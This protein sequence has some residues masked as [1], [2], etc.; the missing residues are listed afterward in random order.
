DLSPL[1]IRSVEI[2]APPSGSLAGRLTDLHSVPLAGVSVL[3]RNLTTG[4]EARA[5]TAKNGAFHFDRLDAGE[6]MLQADAAQLGHGELGGILV[7]GGAVARVQ[8]AMRFEPP[9][10]S[11]IEAAAPSE[12]PAVQVAA[13]TIPLPAY[14]VPGKSGGP[15]GLTSV[16]TSRPVH[17]PSRPA[18]LPPTAIRIEKPAALPQQ[19]RASIETHSPPV[20]LS[21]EVTVPHTLPLTFSASPILP[22][23]AAIASGLHAAL[24]LGE[25][26]YSPIS[27]AA[28]SPDPGA[29]STTTIMTAAQLQSLPAG[30]RR[31]QEFL[32]DTPA[33]SPSADSSEQSYRA[34]QESAGV[35]IDGANTSLRFGV[36][37]GSAA[38]STPQERNLLN[39][40]RQSTVGQSMSQAWNGGRGAGI[41]EAAISEVTATAGNV[42]AKAMRS[43]GGRTGI[44]TERG[45]NA[46]HGQ[47]FLYDRQN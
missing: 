20:S 35:T 24:R 8:A 43:A 15:A 19:L 45:G 14:A 6:Y 32:A 3:L 23:N 9:A 21:L 31:W 37:A 2:Q 18:A 44:E 10:P 7:T 47:G 42:E 39:D 5:V 17:S 25:M 11:L 41:S 28:Q 29:A 33:S 38:G 30:G 13:V 22:M 46:L 4:A 16:T 40:D 26:S 1:P 36:C 34:S 27:A 12:I